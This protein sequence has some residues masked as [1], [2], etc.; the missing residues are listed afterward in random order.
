[1]VWLSRAD[2]DAPYGGDL[3]GPSTLLGLGMGVVLN[4]T[5]VAATSGLPQE[6]AGLAERRTRQSPPRF[7]RPPTE[8]ALV[9]AAGCAALGFLAPLTAP[10][11]PRHTHR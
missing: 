2:A 11:W 1:M 9:G 8:P 5:T 7:W 6:R 10:G 4:A 3:L